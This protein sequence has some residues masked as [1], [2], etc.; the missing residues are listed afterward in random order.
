MFGGKGSGDFP[1]VP[2]EKHSFEIPRKEQKDF[3]SRGFSRC[4]W[5]DVEDPFSR[6]Q[7]EPGIKNYSH[8]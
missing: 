8:L 1:A 5:L 6:Q 3:F 2:N 4:A 7:K